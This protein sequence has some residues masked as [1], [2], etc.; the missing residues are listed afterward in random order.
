MKLIVCT[1]VRVSLLL[2]TFS[3]SG[4]SYAQELPSAFAKFDTHAQTPVFTGDPGKW[5]S[6]IR[7]RGWIL[8]D[9]DQYRM[10]Y[11]GYNPEQQ[12]PTM[13]LGYAT[14]DDGIVWQRH[15]KN[16]IFDDAWVEDMMIVKRNGTFYMFAEGANDQ[17]QLLKSKDGLQWKRM[18]TL[19]VRLTSGKKIPEGAYGT[20]TAVVKDGVWHLFYERRDAGIWLATSKDMKVWTNVSD[21][22]LLLPGP[23]SY[24][25]LMIAMN[26]IVRRNKKW[27]AVLHGTG[28][29]TKPREW[30][31]YFAVSDDLLTWTKC[32][33]G[34]VLPIADNK[35]SG[36]L[37]HDGQRFRLY[38]MHAKVD[39]HL[40]KSKSK[41]PTQPT[42][43]V[44]KKRAP[45]HW[46][47]TPKAMPAGV[48]HATFTSRSMQ[49][50]V[51][52]CIYRPS[53]YQTAAAANKRYPV[54]YYLH[55]GRPGSET[56]SLKL[57]TQI[58]KLIESGACPP[59]IYVFVNGGPVS[60]Y[61]MPER[62]NALGAD[63]FV[64]ELIPHV[65]ATYRTI[66]SREGRGIEGFSQGGRGTTRLMFRYPK[67]FGSAAPGGAGHE[68][69]KSISENGGRESNTLVFTEGDNTYDL[70]RKYA[71]SLTDQS[72][73][74]PILIHVG[75]K[76]FNYQNNLAYME[77]LDELKIPYRRLIVK[78]VPHS[79]AGIYEK[80]GAEIMKFH[81]SNFG[82]LK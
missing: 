64:K 49:L 7:E 18:G 24:D 15:A 14:S 40:A 51:G 52:Y 13:K 71:T 17:A 68:T 50:E 74:L 62:E 29:Q 65:D 42:S 20:P 9:G 53:E 12:S 10:W 55:G 23:D 33:D 21:A 39:L 63:I 46:V 38:T 22:P 37:V 41:P 82:L 32:S 70:A 67:L 1:F 5:D 31:T 78:D 54:V 57:A 26:Q 72:P 25:K 81:A 35:S 11:T 19:D 47:N 76:G 80:R 60:H 59:M 28:S 45:F 48:T 27:Y 61:N 8:K 69:E 3:I 36:V 30:C 34:P 75:T 66:A 44:V 58:H 6:L 16:P 4:S 79:A 73:A 77:F 2:V 56:K 43:A